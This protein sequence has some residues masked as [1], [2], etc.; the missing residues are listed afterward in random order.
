MDVASRIATLGG[1]ART[2]V[3]LNAGH[4]RYEISTALARGV[5]VRLRQGILASPGADPYVIAAVRLG[6]VLT[7]TN[8]LARHG[9]T[10]LWESKRAHVAVRRGFTSANKPTRNVHLHYGHQHSGGDGLSALDGVPRALDAAGACLLPRAHLVAVDS[11]LNKGLVRPDQ[12]LSWSSS[13]RER[14]DWILGHMDGR[15][16][17]AGETLARL[18]L[19]ERDLATHP[20]RFIEGVGHVDLVAQNEVIVEVD[21]RAFH[22]DPEQFKRDRKRD[23]RLNSLGY[24]VQRFAHTELTQSQPV[25]VGDVVAALLANPRHPRN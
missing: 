18:D 21:G 4:S 15:A 9:V 11:A 10:L 2:G 7:C 17:S 16:Q 19:A 13:T 8:A 14:R 1:V 3:L 5:L 23:R 24:K 6:G 25:H 12:I 20:Q 22:T